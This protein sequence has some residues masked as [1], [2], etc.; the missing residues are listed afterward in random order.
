MDLVR[1]AI[2]YDTSQAVAS[3][4]QLDGQLAN[5]TTRTAAVNR[6]TALT[7]FSFNANSNALG[8]VSAAAEVSDTRLK[9]VALA[10]TRL[11]AGMTAGTLSA[12]GL[13]SAIGHLAGASVLGALVI[14]IVNVVNAM[15]EYQRIV[16]DITS[17]IDAM[18]TAARDAKAD[19]AR[20]L[21][22]APAESNA[23]RAIRRLTQAAAQ[24]RREAARIGGAAGKVLEGQAA[25][26]EAQIPTVGA[27]AARQRELQPA[28]DRQKI[29][30]DY[31]KSLQD[32]S[33]IM[34]LLNVGPL[35][36]MKKE[37]E[38]DTDAFQKLIEKGLNP[39]SQRAQDMLLMIQ[40]LSEK[41]RRMEEASKLLR[42]GLETAAQAIEDFVVTGTLAFQDFLD[43]ILRLLYK[44]FT[45]DIITSIVSSAQGS[46]QKSATPTE[47]S[48]SRQ[49]QPSMSTQVNYTVQAVDAQSVASFFERNGGL[50]AAEL[51]RAASRSRALRRRL[52]RG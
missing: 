17:S 7:T 41:I 40:I 47:I 37:L 21:G 30:D 14:T 1:L 26:L 19:V 39:T 25:D 22:E 8:K 33:A 12:S 5:I 18:Q 52:L 10:G 43:N 32:Q 13:A 28:R 29:I 50:M 20:L 42:S 24:L 36:R 16:D 4:Q 45:G 38:L 9:A 34:T 46:S 48:F 44:Q 49:V 51:A 31:N 35:D 2:V 11:A 6:T 15:Q 23:E 3:L 27:R